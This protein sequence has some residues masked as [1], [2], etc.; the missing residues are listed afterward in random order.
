MGHTDKDLILASHTTHA[1]NVHQVV[2]CVMYQDKKKAILYVFTYSGWRGKSEKIKETF[3][4]KI[5]E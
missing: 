3:K 2:M 4:E 5:K 1:T